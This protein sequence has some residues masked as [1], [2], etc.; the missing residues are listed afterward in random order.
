MT[1]IEIEGLAEAI[2]KY[3][4]ASRKLGLAMRET[5]RNSLNVLHEKVP[6]Y[7]P[8]PSDSTYRRTGTLGRSL[9]SRRGGGRAGLPDIYRVTGST[10]NIEGAFGTRLDYAPYVISDD[11]QAWM[12]KGRWWT[13]NTV[14]DRARSKIKKLW[15]D[16]INK[17]LE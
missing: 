4:G 13:M 5:M 12:H 11:D 2:Q 3:R 16:L 15:N 6:P 1:D 17:I 7:P 14:A 10:K 8:P 9:G